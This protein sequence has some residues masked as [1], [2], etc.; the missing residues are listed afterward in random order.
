MAWVA[1]AL[2]EKASAIGRYITIHS[3]Q[4]SADIIGVSGDG[5]AFSRYRMVADTSDEE[6]KI[7]YWKSLKHLGWPID[8][9]I[10]TKLRAGEAIED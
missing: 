1:E 5:R 10:M 7:I 4:Y 8:P 3:Y 9:E 2:P 6:F